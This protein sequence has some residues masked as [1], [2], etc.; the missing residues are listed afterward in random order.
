[1]P[2]QPVTVAI[3]AR[4]STDRQDAR[5]IE[6]QQ[7]RCRA[8][9]TLHNHQV[10][11]EF[12]DIAVSGSHLERADMQRLLTQARRPGGPPFRAVLV[13]DLSRLSRDMG[14]TWQVVFGDLASWG[15]KVI[16]ITTGMSSDGAG[17]RLTF[18]AMALVNDTFL[19]LVR[20]ETHRGL[21]GR[22]LGGFSTGGRVYGYRTIVE[23]NPPDP[24]HPRSIPVIDEAEAETIRRIF[25]LYAEGTGHKRIA[26]ILN[27][28]GLR[29]PYDVEYGKRAGKGWGHST[30]RAMLSNERYLG[31]WVWNK[32][33]WVPVPNKKA[34]RALRRPPSEWVT[35]DVPEL[36]IVPQDLWDR[37]RTRQA[38]RKATSKGRAH[39]EATVTPYLL[40]G[41][42][43]CGTCGSSMSIVS[44][45]VKN[46]RRYPTFG[47][48]AYR[49]KGEAICA[50]RMTVSEMKVT[51]T[52]FAAIQ[53]LLDDPALPD[54]F[55]AG[56][57][58]R[59]GEERHGVAAHIDPEIA[60]LEKRAHNLGEAIAVAG[61]SMTL[62]TQLKAVEERLTQLRGVAAAQTTNQTQPVVA[63]DAE[64]LR[65]YFGELA[66]LVDAA[67]T[68]GTGNPKAWLGEVK[69]TPREVDGRRFYSAS[70][71]IRL[72]PTTLS[73]GRAENPSR[74]H[75]GGRI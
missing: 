37:V 14:G 40:S 9:A 19:Q 51:S 11:A 34:K 67:R 41:L 46:G 21:E 32:R 5:S 64:Q 25:R 28:E 38:D 66:L 31:K 73:N 24:D 42:L 36:A 54:A 71:L 13:D 65:R 57:N 26:C 68:T 8:Y 61:W 48:S 6:D 35:R 52:A 49:S 15:V 1:M 70:G 10:V 17:A 16:D 60:E 50:N 39:G 58:E 12:S 27:A 53:T 20:S 30:I 33:K 75:C 56:F 74:G 4:I 55:V 7:R 3:Y 22:A 47:C 59:L 72:D 18:G 62:G 63:L 43:R 45:Q 44:R 2:A 69:L 29:A 23:P